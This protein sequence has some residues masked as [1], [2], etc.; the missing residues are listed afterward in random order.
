MRLCRVAA[1][2]LLAI[3]SASAPPPAAAS[4]PAPHEMSFLATA[5]CLDGTTAS[6]VQTNRGIAAADL[7]VLPMGTRIRVSGLKRGRNG[8]Y[9]VMDTGEHMQGRRID[10]FIQSCVEAK[11]FGKQR[12]RVAIVR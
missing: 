7:D 4:K 11:R 6:G 12:V 5:Y 1:V 3:T 10:L 2:L 9:R 8:V